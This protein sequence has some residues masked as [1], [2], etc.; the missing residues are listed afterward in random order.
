MPLLCEFKD[1]KFNGSDIPGIFTGDLNCPHVSFGSRLTNAFGGSLLSAINRTNLIHFNN[2]SPTYICSSSGQPNVLDLVL[3]N[4]LI[5]PY[6]LSCQTVGDIGSDHYPVVTLLDLNVKKV[7]MKPKVNFSEW[8]K[9]VDEA[10]P[11]LCIDHLPVDDQVDIIED[12]FKSTQRECTHK[13]H[14]SKRKLPHEIMLTIR[15]RKLLLSQRKRAMSQQEREAITKEYNKVNKKVKFQIQQFEE[16]EREKLASDI[17]EAKDTNRMWKLFK[18]FKTRNK[19]CAEHI[20]PL[21]LQ[22]GKVTA[23][24]AEKSAEFARHLENVHQTPNDPACDLKFRKDID[25]YFSTFTEPPPCEDG[26]SRIDVRQFREILAQTK[27]NS[28]PGEDAITYDVLK[29]CSDVS[30]QTLCNLINRC[31]KENVFPKKW[32]FAKLLWYLNH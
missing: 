23:S 20:S 27:N 3:G 11:K 17:C 28:S 29:K 30:I 26:I 6:F 2:P 18:K 13:V 22:N 16:Q 15:Q 19:E 25:S 31:L 14:R 1:I 12:I 9:K 4:N 8:V 7:E 32:K 10:L 5:C 21:E 24:N